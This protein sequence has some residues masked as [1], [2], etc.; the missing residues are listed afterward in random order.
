[1]V[2][3]KRVHV[4]SLGMAQASH[5][6]VLWHL[7][8]SHYNE[9]A[10]WAL[11]YKGVA[12]RRG[13]PPPGMHP[14]FALAMT[15][16]SSRLPILKLDDRTIFD[17]TRIIA[18]LERRVPDPP[19]YPDDAGERERALRLEDDL[20]ESLAPDVRRFIFHHLFADPELLVRVVTLDQPGRQQRILRASR[21]IAKPL[22]S[23]RYQISEER[24]ETAEANIFV[25]LD[26]I[27]GE[28]DGSPYLVGERF[29]V[30]DLTA[31]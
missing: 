17:S 24:A 20:D 29:S 28:L 1:M 15:R 19:L 3:V 12:H 2:V 6:P 10:R 7:R 27:A 4:R 31:A 21:P 23:W 13:E 25:N 14:V 11:D 16:R 30:A 26:R 8:V 22:M 18:E 5:A 9:K